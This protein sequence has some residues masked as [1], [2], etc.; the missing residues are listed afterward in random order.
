MTDGGRDAHGVPVAAGRRRVDL[1]SVSRVLRSDLFLFLLFV[2]ALVLLIVVLTHLPTHEQWYDE[3]LPWVQPL[4]TVLALVAATV[5]ARAAVRAYRLEV[6]RN[7]ARADEQRAAQASLVAAWP[8]LLEHQAG[9]DSGARGVL[10]YAIRNASDLPV[11]DVRVTWIEDTGADAAPL[12]R[13]FEHPLIA[14]STGPLLFRVGTPDPA[15][16]DPTFLPD[17]TAAVVRLRFRDAANTTW[18]RDTRGWLHAV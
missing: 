15:S 13:E 3:I 5:A 11:T 10:G 14:P 9:Q 18:E 1:S 16:S 17:E 4:A 2:A 8:V 12:E 6:R 7:A